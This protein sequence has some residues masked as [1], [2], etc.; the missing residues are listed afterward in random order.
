MRALD[1]A[2]TGMQAQQ[3]NVET[4]S[5]N[6][7]NMTT[8][9][10]KR[11]R[12]EFQD[13]MYQDLR[14]V[15]SNSSDSGTVVPSGAQLGLG[16]KTAAIYRI[17]EQGNL[18]QTSNTLDLAIQ[19]NGYF[20]V[21]LPSGDTA[22]TRDGTFALAADGT[23]VTAD[24]YAVAPGITVP[25]NAENVSINASGQVQVTV[26]GQTAAQTVGQIQLAVFP[27]ETGLDA[28][29]DNL[30]TQTTA[31]GAPTTGTPGAAGFGSVMQGFVES[32]N[33]NVVTEITDLITAQRAYEMNSKVIT[34]ADDM[35]QTL[36]NLK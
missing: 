33:V 20:Q 2:G 14:R 3:T 24:G 30:L 17:N 13:L 27:N 1:I 10:F 19:G 36:T 4:I 8:T 11:R 21:T 6:I 23:I 9:G 15:G 18:T 26:A 31:S 16:V 5:N 34:A 32:S 35:M 28:K 12:A 22:Y 7:A 25:T 29:G